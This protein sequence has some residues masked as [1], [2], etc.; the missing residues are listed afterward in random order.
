MLSNTYCLIPDYQEVAGPLTEF[1]PA[2]ILREVNEDMNTIINRAFTFVETGHL[3]SG[4]EFSMK[5]TFNYVA[6]EL[7]TRGIVLDN[8]STVVYANAIQNVG[9]AFMV[10]ISSSP[11]WFTRYGKW[12]GARY[13]P[14]CIGGV[15]VYLDHNQHKLPQ[16]ESAEQYQAITPRLLTVVDMLI[17]NLGGRL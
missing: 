10:A 3:D 12:V 4:L 7:S 9:K 6:T 1:D 11:Y 2:S 14:T 8:D 17:G 5:N 16:F 15:D 13:S